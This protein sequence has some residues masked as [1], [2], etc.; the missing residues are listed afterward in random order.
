MGVHR[1]KPNFDDWKA[2]SDFAS[3]GEMMYPTSKS[4]ESLEMF[5]TVVARVGQVVAAP[6]HTVSGANRRGPAVAIVASTIG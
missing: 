5:F 1:S 6:A 3:V 2:S 4:A